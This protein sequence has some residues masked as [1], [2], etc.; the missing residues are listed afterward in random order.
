[1][2]RDADAE[3]HHISLSAQRQGVG[4]LGVFDESVP[5]Q[6][7]LD[8]ARGRDQTQFRIEGLRHPPRQI[9]AMHLRLGP[10]QAAQ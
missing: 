2:Q 6:F 7:A 4:N 5:H 9:G 10:S 8:H 1:M 3:N